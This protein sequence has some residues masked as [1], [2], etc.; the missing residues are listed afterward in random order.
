MPRGTVNDRQTGS[1]EIKMTLFAIG[2]M[3][4]FG[5]SFW[6]LVIALEGIPPVT[7][8]FL[9]AFLV[10][11]FM[12]LVFLFMSKVSGRKNMTKRDNILYGGLKGRK[13]LPLVVS[14][15]FFSTVLPNLFQNIGMTL[16]DPASTSSLA[17]LIQ[18]V[19]PVFTIILAVILLK[20]GLGKWKIMGLFL[21]VP[22]TVILT[23]YGTGGIDI[24]SEQTLGAFL[25]LLTAL[26]Y[27]ISGVLLKTAMNRGAGPAHLVSANAMYGTVLL[28]PFA[29]ICW[30]V[31][32][33]DP[34][35]IFG[36][37]AHV[38]L[39]LFF[40]SVGLYGITAIVW[41]IVIR[42][43]E[44]SRVT[45]FVF[46]IPI[47]SYL[48]GYIMLDERLNTIQLLAGSLLLFGVGIS[49]IRGEKVL[50]RDQN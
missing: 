16:M 27:S 6:G 26:S 30:T 1:N 4:L 48:V 8:G 34:L 42:S 15:A 28:L 24:N 41:Y 50:S 25:N 29:L 37:G 18:G 47:F 33:E 36:S 32:W 14:F 9:R 20:E 17:A 10:T 23:T 21:A 7:L 11:S 49:Q 31:G 38:W 12:L 35:S 19:S 44:L 45:F 2:S 5:T 13:A 43:G 3:L 40:T 46:L 22:A 39:A